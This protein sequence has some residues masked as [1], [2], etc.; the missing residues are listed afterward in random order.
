MSASQDL[1]FLVFLLGSIDIMF[2]SQLLVYTH[3]F[4]P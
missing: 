3:G 4:L 1:F 2:P